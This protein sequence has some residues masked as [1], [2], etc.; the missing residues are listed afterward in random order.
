MYGWV[1][2][3]KHLFWKCVSMFLF[4]VFAIDFH[5]FEEC[6]LNMFH[7]IWWTTVTGRNFSIRFQDFMLLE[8][9][10]NPQL[11]RYLWNFL[12][13]SLGE[14][15]IKIKFKLNLWFNKYQRIN[16]I[17]MIDHTCANAEK[18]RKK[19]TLPNL[20]YHISIL[21]ERYVHIDTMGW[22]RWGRL[23]NL[24]DDSFDSFDFFSNLYLRYVSLFVRSTDA[25]TSLKITAA[26]LL[27]R[28]RAPSVMRFNR[29]ESLTWILLATVELQLINF[30]YRRYRERSCDQRG[31]SLIYL[32]KM[33]AI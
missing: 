28:S 1:F 12:G 5:S 29:D 13:I 23:R 22:F 3:P 15:L 25:P 19:L 24:K 11:T 2:V 8:T 26:K 10:V 27:S 20:H 32:T 18:I 30:D 16:D 17:D 21:L 6:G 33:P 7:R 4:V 31:W 9:G 14:E